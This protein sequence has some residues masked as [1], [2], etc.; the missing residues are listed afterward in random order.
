M[1]ATDT[2]AEVKKKLPRTAIV[3]A[4]TAAMLGII[5]GYDN[6][7]IG[8]AQLFFQGELDSPRSR[9]NSSSPPSSTAR[10]S[11]RSS[12]VSS[13]TRSVERSR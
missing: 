1:A 4:A 8:G 9:P 3:V 7:V 6:G 5:Y 2:S 13:P 12:R 11:A 10:S